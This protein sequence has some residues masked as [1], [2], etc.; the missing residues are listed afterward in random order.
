MP[1]GWPLLGWCSALLLAMAGG[2]L[3][4]HGAGEDGLRAVVRATARTSLGLFL[5][6]YTASALRAL[7]PTAATAWLVA[8]RRQLGLAFAVS[9][10]LHLSAIVRLAVLAPEFRA[11]LAPATI[12]GG[13]GAYVVILAMAA[14][15]F[16]ATAA[17][18]GRRAWTA[19]HA[20]G[21]HYVW[22]VFVLSY[23]PR[24]VRGSPAAGAFAVLLVGGL[25]VRLAARGRGPRGSRP[26]LDASPPR[27]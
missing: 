9:H 5:A 25:G 23:V 11:A 22:L 6:A 10:V 8:N 13:G 4:A 16:D 21:L 26:A 20:T 17:R 27:A 2:L 3:L 7:R 18:I 14:T 1:R 19:L 24:A 15:S 12:V